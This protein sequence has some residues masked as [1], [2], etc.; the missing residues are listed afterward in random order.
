MKN[1]IDFISAALPWLCMGLFLAIFFAK[2]NRKKK[3]EANGDKEK[4][5]YSSEGM[6]IGMCL[7]VALGVSF[8]NNIGLGISLGML[9]GL[10]IGS[11]I[12]KKKN[13]DEK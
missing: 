6:S 1:V 9:L 3:D 13:K 12:E 10:A 8:G 5:D 7:G 4:E 11:C 2:N